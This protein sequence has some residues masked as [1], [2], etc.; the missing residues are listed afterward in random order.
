[1]AKV[2]VWPSRYVS[3]WDGS[4][5]IA[6]LDVFEIVDGEQALGQVYDTDA[7]FVPYY[8]EG[9]T[10]MPRLN[11]ACL[12]TLK[13]R[14][15]RV[16]FDWLVVDVDA[17]G[18]ASPDAQWRQAEAHKREGLDA[19]HYETRGGYRL[20]WRLERPATVDEYL[21][22]LAAMRGELAEREIIADRLVDWTRS[23][24]LPK[25]WRDGAALDGQVNLGGMGSV[26]ICKPEAGENRFDG[27]REARVDL[28]V[29]GT[30]TTGGRN[31]LLARVGGMLRR[32][33]LD[34]REI[35]GCLGVVNVSRCNP[36]LNEEEVRAVAVSMGRYETGEEAERAARFALGSDV[37]IGD[38]ACKLLEQGGERLVGDEGRLWQYNETLGIWSELTE[39][40]VRNVVAE[41]DGESVVGSRGQ[42]VPLKVGQR[43]CANVGQRIQEKR[44]DLGFFSGSPGG[45]TFKNGYVT[46]ED[47]AVVVQPFSAEQRARVCIKHDFVASQEPNRFLAALEEC[48]EDDDDWEQKIAFL[49]EFVGVC[50]L[51]LAPKFQKGVILLGEGANGKSTIQT[52]IGELFGRDLRCSLP[53]HDMDSEYRRAMIAGKRLNLVNELP[54]ADILA[55]EAT[56]ALIS[57]DTMT[58]RHI[59][60]S[61]FE[62]LP[63]AGHLYAANA[64]PGVR[65]MSLGFW[66]RWVILEFGRTFKVEERVVGLADTIVRSELGKVY[67]WALDGAAR[68][69]RRQAFTIPKSSR[70][71]TARWKGEADQV[72]AF[73]YTLGA[74]EVDEAVDYPATK[75]Y[76]A[77]CLWASQNGHKT[78]SSTKFGRRLAQIGVEKKRKKSGVVY[79]V[80]AEI[81]SASVE[82]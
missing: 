62:F 23:Y 53:P 28:S 24:R 49:Q 63:E 25:V 76:N 56:K 34:V 20:L 78:M 66:R 32:A 59:R 6:E 67:S 51:G 45:L 16:L 9:E 33:G 10:R 75:L 15:K 71:A 11:K 79:S 57:G 14:G 30:T 80:G 82:I 70:Q 55:S 17:P 18:H 50:L 31:Q 42:L 40:Q 21:S 47:G 74:E 48:W 44:Q 72:L 39:A 46:V 4:S 52:I 3:G 37:E 58:G 2:V 8:I 64:L 68:A 35:E 13:E 38:E 69:L 54:E 27:I 7:H 26:P 22:T 29:S 81:L 41:F 19:G 5:A 12:P 61:P 1:M 65:D 36:P 73:L 43:L 60:Q 77:Y